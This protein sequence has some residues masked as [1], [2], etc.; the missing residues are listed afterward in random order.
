MNSDNPTKDKVGKNTMAT[1]GERLK[2]LREERG[3]TQPEL[4][5]ALGVT[6][7]TIFVWE[8]EKRK[9]G[10]DFD[11]FKAAKFFDVSYF[12]LMG[13]SEVRKDEEA[14]LSDEEVARMLDEDA[15]IYIIGAL[16]KYRDLSDEM[17]FMVRQ[18]LEN[19]YEADRERVELR[20]QRAAVRGK[21]YEDKI[22]ALLDSDDFNEA[23]KAV[24]YPEN[25]DK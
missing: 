8:K 12:Y 7:N 10:K 18:T 9:P 20:S 25:G 11:P 21:T 22:I 15:L 13:I 23:V 24:F 16:K 2:E 19:A 5:E 14:E 17:Q 6:T 4:A 1:F 3:L